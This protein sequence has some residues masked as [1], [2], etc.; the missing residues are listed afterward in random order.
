MKSRFCGTAAP[1]ITK[2]QKPFNEELA[3]ENDFSRQENKISRSKRGK[4]VSF[5]DT[6]R[7]MERHAAFRDAPCRSA[8]R[9][10]PTVPK[11]VPNCVLA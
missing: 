9:F 10:D 1:L 11:T 7:Q 4:R 5:T 6:D 8:P 2:I 3:K